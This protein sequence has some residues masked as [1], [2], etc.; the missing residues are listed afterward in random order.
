MKWKGEHQNITAVNKMLY[1]QKDIKGDT[2]L[3]VG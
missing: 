3:W 1:A 2:V